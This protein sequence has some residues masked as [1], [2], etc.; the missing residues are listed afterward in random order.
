M[1]NNILVLAPCPPGVGG[2]AT[3]SKMI[4]DYSTND[5]D[6]KL[7]FINVGSN[8]VDNMNRNILQRVFYGFD[9]L[10]DV[11]K[12]VKNLLS[13]EKIDLFH[14][15]VTGS[16]SLFRDRVLI[17]IA[18]KYNIPVVLHIRIGR[19]PS[20]K[21]KNTFE[22]IYFKHNLK[23]ADKIITI[24][25]TTYHSLKDDFGNVVNV[26]NP[27]D[28]KKYANY[29]S[30]HFQ[31]GVIT[32]V[33]WIIKEKGIEEL[34]S[35]FNK[36]HLNRPLLL[37]LVG[38]Y[39][40]KYISFL[41]KKYDFQNVQLFGKIGNAETLQIVANSEIFV[42]PSY[43]EG[44]PNSVLESMLCKTPIIASNVGAIP[45]MLQDERGIVVKPQDEDDLLEKIVWLLED[46]D[47]QKKLIDNAY[48]RVLSDFSL[49][50]IYQVYKN[51][52]NDIIG[53][54]G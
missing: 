46:F 22:W 45:E 36:I 25:E 28:T 18:K 26:I 47:L 11:V 7:Y 50:H 31:N 32:Y 48:E 10:F 37:K 23:K 33:G 41:K 21:R 15:T 43:T 39:N 3:W 38:P 16:L 8:K 20:I 35:C 54:R 53:K 42:L 30:M 27:I 12:Q 17:K 19:I 44:C 14:M 13:H 52:W 9:D 2:I 40:S 5:Q 29:P 1:K 24:D 6:N 49:E 34:L 4:G 51:I